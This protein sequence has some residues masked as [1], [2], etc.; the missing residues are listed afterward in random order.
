VTIT[1]TGTLR[2]GA[3]Y[4]PEELIVPAL[5]GLIDQVTAVLLVLL[6]VALNC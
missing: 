1:V 3:A 4:K 2:D 5:V 6:T